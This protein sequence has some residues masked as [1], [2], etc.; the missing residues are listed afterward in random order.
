MGKY[1]KDHRFHIP[2]D[3]HIRDSLI[4]TLLMNHSLIVIN[5]KSCNV[6]LREMATIASFDGAWNSIPCWH[7]TAWKIAGLLIVRYTYT[8]SHDKPVCQIKVHIYLSILLGNFMFVLPSSAIPRGR[9]GNACTHNSL[10]KKSVVLKHRQ[11]Y[12]PPPPFLL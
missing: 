6:I 1:Y 3:C 5:G 10:K 11:K 8:C 2:I 12:F 9:A 7:G 4:I